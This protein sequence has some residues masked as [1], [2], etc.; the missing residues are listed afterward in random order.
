MFAVSKKILLAFVVLTTVLTTGAWQNTPVTAV[1]SQNPD[2]IE[3]PLYPGL[4]WSSL[5]ASS[6]DIRVN[7]QGDSVS[8]SGEG[9]QAQE[10]LAADLPLSAEVLD[11]Y[12]NGKLAASGW[13]SYDALSVADG[14]RFVFYHQSGVYFSVDYVNCQD[15]ASKTCIS[16]WKS[17]PVDPN[18]ELVPSAAASSLGDQTA[19]G[20]FGKKSPANGATGL[21]PTSTTLSWT[22][23]NP[24]PAKYKY[25]VKEASACADNDSDYTSVYG[26]SITL[27]SNKLLYSK[28]YYWQVKAVTCITCTPKTT[29]P[30]DN[31]TAWY[32]S[33]KANTEVNITGNAGVSGAV[34]SYVNSTAKT[35]TADSS[36]AY[37][38]KVP[39]GWSGTLTPS[40]T[41]YQFSPKSASFTNVSA[42]QI[43]Q[44]FTAIPSFTISGNVGAPGVTLSYTDGTP[45]TV[46]SDVNG[47]YSISVI[48]GWSGTV[49]PSSPGYVF[50]P[51]SKTYPPLSANQTGQNYTASYLTYT[52]SGNVEIAGT[53]LSYTDGYPKKATSAADGSY[54]F[55]VSQGWTGTVTPSH[56]CYTFT[57]ASRDYTNVQANQVS[58]YTADATALCVS[59]IL[60]LNGSPTSAATVDYSVIFT[61]SVTGVDS[62]DFKVT[63]AG[64]SWAGVTNIAGTG[65]SYTVTVSTG[66]GNGTIRLDLIDNDSIKDAS[67]NPL[68]GAGSGNGNYTSG[69]IYTVLK[70]QTF[71]DVPSNHQYYSD[72]EVL[73]A[74]RLTS[75]CVASPLSYCPNQNLDRAQTAVFM[76]RGKYG[77]GYLPPAGLTYQFQDDWSKGPWAQSWAEAMRSAGITAGCKTNPPL[78]CPW[79]QLPKEQ[80]VVFGLRMEYGEDYAPPAATGTIFAD[81]TDPT[82]WATSWAEQAYKDGLIPP[83]GMSGGKP[84][85]CPKNIASR[86]LGAYIIVRAK[87]LITP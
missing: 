5:G 56:T 24:T 86:G 63:V 58:N 11:F 46:I 57:P 76:M 3:T 41:G 16:V 37:S 49:T 38:L 78:Y 23:Y 26:T 20:S 44:N 75:G 48:A 68:G 53:T 70:S 73:Y 84:L 72:I 59:S 30:A 50:A 2:S 81:M 36:G 51:T 33:T 69:Q 55:N 35:V 22:A 18:V 1:K 42:Q 61:D 83:C 79:E 77:A 87:G 71:V 17:E 6:Q 15:D 82:Y 14:V 47:N 31:G 13:E 19:T 45:K 29:V 27:P 66:S 12:S 4:T 85:F 9:F 80:V 25:C 67:N 39:V 64:I 28:T 34:I 8:L 65:A 7:I 52:I 10:Q 60:R 62:S 54:S 40:K 74:N 43:I 21:N 32:F